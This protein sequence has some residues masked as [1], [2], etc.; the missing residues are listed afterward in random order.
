MR[1]KVEFL[2][3]KRKENTGKVPDYFNGIKV[4]DAVLDEKE[5]NGIRVHDELD[6]DT[7]VK[8]IIAMNPDYRIYNKITII[9]AETD[10]EETFAKIRWDERN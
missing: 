5:V 2:K 10:I 4:S 8:E 3:Q 1:K 7:N 6:L 9:N